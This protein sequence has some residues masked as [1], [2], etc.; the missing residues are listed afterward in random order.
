MV[1]LSDHVNSVIASTESWL[2]ISKRKGVPLGIIS[3]GGKDSTSSIPLTPE[4][5]QEAHD[6]LN[7]GYGM[8]GDLKKFVI[9]AASLNFT[10]ISL[11]V[12]DLM[13]L[14]GVEANSRHI[15]NAYGFP[16]RLMEYDSGSSLSNGGEVKE[17]EKRHY[18]NQIIP[19]AETICETI[20]NWWMMKGYSL[21]VF[22]D[23]LEIFQKSKEETGRAILTLCTGLDKAYLNKIITLEEYRSQLAQ[24]MNIDATKPN[25]N[26]YYTGG[27]GSNKGS[28]SQAI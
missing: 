28:Q 10:A 2:T 13:L 19:D 8:G 7:T 5:K 24:I 18:S 1:P 15:A 14:E 22:F 27:T 25:G 16:F 23:H 3:S 20:S 4:E 21:Q 17:A 6:E 11:P 9:T 26:T 12:R